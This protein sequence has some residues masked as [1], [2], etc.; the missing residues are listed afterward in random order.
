MWEDISENKAAVLFSWL[1]WHLGKEKEGCPWCQVLGVDQNK[2]KVKVLFINEFPKNGYKSMLQDIHSWKLKFVFNVD[3][4]WLRGSWARLLR[5]QIRFV[6][7]D[8]Q[9]KYEG[10]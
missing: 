10:I 7:K 6:F 2:N 5:S 1:L 8:R 3:M 9:R 4:I